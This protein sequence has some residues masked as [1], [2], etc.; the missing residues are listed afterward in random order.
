[1]SAKPK[2]QPILVPVDFSPHSQAALD[3]AANLAVCMQ[4]PIL[5]LHVV[6][7]PGG[8]PSYYARAAKKKF[9]LRVEDLAQEMFDEF[10]AEA[11]KRHPDN[12]ALKEAETL[13]VQGIPG[14]RILEVA[15]D[16]DA[17]MVVMGSK[18]ETGFKHLL[19]GSVATNVV[20]LSPVPVTIVKAKK[21]K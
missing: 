20:Q 15:D 2:A 21:S 8:V 17:A 4:L 10:V 12:E 18:G 9:L 14:T 13:M 6:H 11:R 1:M 5:I 19:M 7:D 3:Y 16:K